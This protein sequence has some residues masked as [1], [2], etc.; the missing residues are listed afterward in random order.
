MWR[1]WPLYLASLCCALAAAPPAHAAKMNAV[2]AAKAAPSA[3]TPASLGAKIFSDPS[4]SASGQ[5]SCASCHSP[6]HAHAAP[7]NTGVVPAGGATLSTPGFR[8]APSLR[9]LNFGIAF[10][11]DDEGTPTGGF[12]RDGRAQ[13]LV[14]QADRPLLAPHEMANASPAAVVEKL[15]NAAYADEFRRVYGQNVF[16]DVDGAYFR[17]RFSIEQFE[18]TAPEMHPFDSKYDY[19]LKGQVKL[20]AQEL[21]GLYWFNNPAKGNCAG[22]HPSSRGGDGSPPLF[23][24]YTYDNLGV[25][26]NLAIPATNDS[27]YVDLGL[28]GPDRIDLADRSDLCG[29]FKVPTLRNVATRSVFFHNG[30]FTRLIDALRFYV[31]RDTNPEQFYPV[32]AN[33]VVHKFDDLPPNLVAN[34]NT[35][36]VPYDRKPGQTPH[37]DEAQLADLAAFLN[38]LTDGYDAANDSADPARNLST[39]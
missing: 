8:T 9:Y 1:R 11:F 19:F 16:D 24:D 4:L 14:E 32:D 28:C 21:R 37:L 18:N 22:C 33:G 20:N 17:L 7:P 5:L 26:R 29:A 23:T 30:R 6:A 34:V 3:P 12:N 25:P 35:V 38:T 15:K 36:E 13:S 31:R 10:F 27:G 2:V 39:H